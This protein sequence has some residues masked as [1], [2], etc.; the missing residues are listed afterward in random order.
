MS[1]VRVM[2][3]NLENLFLPGEDG[4]PTTEAAFQ[5][6]LSSLAA[7]IDQVA[8][9]VAAVQEIGPDPALA[10]LQATLTHQLPHATTGDPD[11]RQIRVAILSAH[12]L[13]NITK[14]R[15][16]PTGVRAVQSKDEVFNDPTTAVDEA[17]TRQ[18]G[19][20]ALGATIQ[21]NGTPVT[22]VTAH[23][24]SK[25]I[26]YARKRGLVDGSKFAPNDEGERLRYAGYALFRRTGEAM[27]ARAGLDQL[28][29]DPAS[30]TVGLGRERAVVFCGDLNDEP[31]AA[32]TQI[33][34]GPTGSDI[35][36]KAG[37]AF[38]RPDADDGF[39]LWNLAP[40]LPA[41]QRFTRVF[42]G[43][44][45]LIDHLF[46]SHRLVNPG[47]LPTVLTIRSVEPL[48]S[49]GDDPSGRRNEPGS[50]HAA[51]VATFGL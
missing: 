37:S 32:T 29:V 42:K 36:L 10:R 1:R 50:D 15:P 44:G 14:I 40:L 11:D 51:V 7:V 47:N 5:D 46:A 22:V 31:A 33:V 8:P 13:A 6:K 43:R 27:T 38:Q 19:R 2:T 30:P 34:A 12:P 49:I 23:F 25:L 41:D 35:D 20:S 21:V 39:R 16:F 3:W 18:M 9:D 28:L 26:N 17:M 45:E 4:G 48:P 24:K